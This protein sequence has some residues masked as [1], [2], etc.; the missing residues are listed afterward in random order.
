VDDEVEFEFDSKAE[1]IAEG[2][3]EIAA[4]FITGEEAEVTGEIFLVG[5]DAEPLLSETVGCSLD[6]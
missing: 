5:D 4:D 3:V 6:D 1:E 2:A